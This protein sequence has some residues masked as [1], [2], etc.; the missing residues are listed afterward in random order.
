MFLLLSLVLNHAYLSGGFVADDLLLVNALRQQPLPYSRWLGLWSVGIE[1]VPDF[2]NLWWFERGTQGGFFRPL[3]SLILEGSYRLFKDNALPLHLLSIVLHGLV[4]FTTFRLFARLTGRALVAFVAGLLFITCEDHSLTVGW[5]ATMTDLLCVTFINAALLAHVSWRETGRPILLATSLLC[6]ALALTCKESAVVAPLSVVLLEW[7]LTRSEKA[8]FALAIKRSWYSA[9]ILFV[10]LA[11][12]E[13]LHLGG[14]G[15]LLYLDP[16]AQTRLYLGNV[17]TAMP[18]MFSGALTL[19]PPILT[20][21]APHTSVPLAL[22]GGLV[23]LLFLWGIWPMRREPV[24]QWSLALF[25]LALLPQAATDPSGRLLY[26]PFVPMSYLLALLLCTTAPLARRCHQRGEEPPRRPPIALPTRIWGWYV[27]IGL[28]LPGAVFSAVLPK[29]YLASMQRPEHDVLT[30]LDVVRAHV[31]KNPDGTVVIL[32]TS[33]QFLTLYVGGIYQFNLRRTVPTRILSSLNGQVTL[34][35]TGLRSFVLSTDRPGW[36]GN[37]FARV[38][39]CNR[40]LTPGRV[41]RT[42][43]FDAALRRLT[44]DRTDVLS[45]EFHFRRPL[46]DPSL[47]FLTWN[48]RA[49]VPLDVAALE[50]GRR[51]PLANTSDIWRSMT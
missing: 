39:R 36:L 1:Q 23:W 44:P 19:I 13:L 45:V 48:G 22:L 12:Y 31:E 34:E 3:P 9:A 18:V 26:Y 20:L 6:L 38:V 29:T 41:Y 15:N 50:L 4:A 47:L 14:M 21:F 37:L 5:I 2:T 16:L 40:Q 27:L 8:P 25:V 33:G 43:L 28:F 51:M 10:F 42:S 24:V 49:F 35:R 11:A 7:L 17:A 32:N 46:D 30:S